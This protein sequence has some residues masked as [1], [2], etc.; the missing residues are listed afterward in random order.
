MKLSII[1]PVYN[2][3]ATVGI[4]LGEVARVRLPPG[5]DR[6]LI[7]INDGSADPTESEILSFQGNHSAL[8]L[9]Y[10]KEPVNRGKGYCIRKGISYASGDVL[11]IQDADL[12]Y[13]PRDYGRLLEPIISNRA[14]V[15]YGSRFLGRR[16]VTT[17][18]HHSVNRS[19]TS[20]MNLF[21][22]LRLSDVHTGLKMFRASVIRPISL[23]ECRFGFCPEVTA[24]LA[25]VPGVRWEEVPVSY[26]RRG[27][28]QGKK[29][30]IKDGLRALYCIVRY[31]AFPRASVRQSDARTESSNQESSPHSQTDGR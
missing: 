21:S 18:T 5:V 22:G 14:D 24:K 8:P 3:A 19:L 2:E 9:L 7:V 25:R 13:D 26:H 12:E 1:L 16:K 29:I 15:V 20:L 27:R 30:G 28:D 10:R 17:W 6:E 31:N 11:V 23:V 4:I